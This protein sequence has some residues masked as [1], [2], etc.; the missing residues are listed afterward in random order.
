[1]KIKSHKLT[2]I[3][4]H[5]RDDLRANAIKLMES[6]NS[7][8]EKAEEQCEQIM[9]EAKKAY[10]AAKIQSNRMNKEAD[11]IQEA[12]N[13]ELELQVKEEQ[14]TQS[15]WEVKST[16]HLAAELEDKKAN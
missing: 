10:H 4:M 16:S 14:E 3:V 13:E 7:L 5:Q 2:A 6:A 11:L 1:M 12:I 9:A 15:A 8:M